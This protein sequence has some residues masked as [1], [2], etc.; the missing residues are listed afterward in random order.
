MSDL[1]LLQLFIKIRHHSKDIGFPHD[2]VNL[3]A[4]TRPLW[5]PSWRCINDALHGRGILLGQDGGFGNIL[6]SHCSLN[7]IRGSRPAAR[8]AGSQQAALATNRRMA[9]TPR[10]M[11]GSSG[12]PGTTW[13]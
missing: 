6:K 13:M 3:V 1:G 2:S 4:R 10:K 9:G 12:P 8:R 7:A 5:R 11:R